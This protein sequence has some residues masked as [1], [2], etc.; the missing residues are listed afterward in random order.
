MT[1]FL[2]C[3]FAGA[4]LALSGPLAAQ[5]MKAKKDTRASKAAKKAAKKATDPEQNWNRFNK[6]S[7]REIKSLENQKAGKK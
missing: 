7:Q 3:L 2:V 6:D 5:E 4:A 1:R